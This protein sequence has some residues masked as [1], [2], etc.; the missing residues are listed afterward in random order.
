MGPLWKVKSFSFW[1]NVVI[2][3]MSDG[4]MSIV[5]WILL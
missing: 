2:P 1:L 5:D 3:V 4:S